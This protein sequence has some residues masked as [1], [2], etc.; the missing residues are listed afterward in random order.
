MLFKSNKAFTLIELLAS[1][2][3]LSI[4]LSISII[5]FDKIKD[6]AKNK[7]LLIE[8]QNYVNSINLKSI[9]ESESVK[10][11]MNNNIRNPEVETELSS[12]NYDNVL[13]E[14]KDGIVKNG[15]F[16]LTKD[17][18]R[19]S[20]NYLKNEYNI[21]NVNNCDLI[22]IIGDYDIELDKINI[23]N[24]SKSNLNEY[25]AYLYSDESEEV[26]MY[27]KKNNNF[28]KFDNKIWKIVKTTKTDYA[29]LATEYLNNK[30]YNPY[31]IVDVL[32]NWYNSLNNSDRKKISKQDFYYYNVDYEKMDNGLWRFNYTKSD[33]LFNS[34]VGL[35]TMEELFKLKENIYK[36]NNLWNSEVTTNTLE[37]DNS[38]ILNKKDN[39]IYVVGEMFY[40]VNS[41]A[42]NHRIYPYIY[43]SKKYKLIGEGTKENPFV[44]EEKE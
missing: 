18:N 7:S 3:I 17:S 24:N 15:F 20:I 29:L 11:N 14:L 37:Y 5:S 39:A 23:N 31:E 30:L 13:I 25:D 35:L 21:T 6:N 26:S 12:Y 1:I 16:C 44:I 32:N 10:K 8:I 4:I 19:Y 27:Y 22:D 42:S 43:I 9:S 38:Y 41:N 40:L 2:V 28:V 36:E 33:E 34:N